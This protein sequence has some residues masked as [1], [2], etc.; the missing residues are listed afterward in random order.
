MAVTDGALSGIINRRNR[1]KKWQNDESK[2]TRFV[3]TC[4]NVSTS[5]RNKRKHVVWADQKG[6]MLKEIHYSDSL[7][8]SRTQKMKMQKHQAMKTI[9]G[10]FFGI[11]CLAVVFI[12]LSRLKLIVAA[13]SL[14]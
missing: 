8:Y 7:H 14:P 2:K 5:K 11:M 10:A 13:T 1:H 4:A 3:S 12:F 6:Q 9:T